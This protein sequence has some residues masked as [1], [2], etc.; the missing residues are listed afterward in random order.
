MGES[1]EKLNEVYQKLSDGDISVGEA[2]RDSNRL[3]A[4][5]TKDET[6]NLVNQH[7]QKVF[8]HRDVIDAETQ[9]HKDYP[10]YQEFV[11]SGKAQEYMKKNPLLVDEVIAFFQ[12]KAESGQRPTET[13]KT[14]PGSN[15]TKEPE[16]DKIFLK[17]GNEIEQEQIKTVLS[18][19]DKRPTRQE[20][21]TLSEIENQQMTTLQKLR[22][23]GE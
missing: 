17:H 21:I 4:Q 22:G 20:P 18:M 3:T 14:E 16:K 1:E 15:V 5:I 8:Q 6:A 11:E 10:D 13:T 19:R 7:T 12:H 2:I 9:W 23:K